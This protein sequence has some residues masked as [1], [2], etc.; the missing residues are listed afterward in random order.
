MPMTRRRGGRR[1]AL[2]CKITGLPVPVNGESRLYGGPVNGGLTETGAYGGWAYG[3]PVLTGD[4][5]GK[6]RPRYGAPV[7]CPALSARAIRTPRRGG[8]QRTG[9]AVT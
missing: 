5:G 4:R 1:G 6:P 8:A 7:G 9:R 3:V 2:Y